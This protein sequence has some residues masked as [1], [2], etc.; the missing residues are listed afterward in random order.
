MTSFRI[1]SESKLLFKGHV[2]LAVPSPW[3]WGD[4]VSF[5][6]GER[7]KYCFGR[8]AS[9]FHRDS[10]SH[11][12]P[13]AF[14]MFFSKRKIWNLNKLEW[15]VGFDLFSCPR[16]ALSTCL[17]FFFQVQDCPNLWQK[18]KKK[19]KEEASSWSSSPSALGVYGFN[20]FR[21]LTI[22]GANH[23]QC[24]T[25]SENQQGC[26]RGRCRQKENKMSLTIP[27]TPGLW[28]AQI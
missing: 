18:R 9:L 3:I 15:E 20:L 19:P 1:F 5:D 14:K 26:G 17:S 8:G 23:P 27:W 12:E 25:L 13:E 2:Y 16:W 4:L 24:S 28:Q 6:H 11:Q 7:P 21:S 22:G 10:G